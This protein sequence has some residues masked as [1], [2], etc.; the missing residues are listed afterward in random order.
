MGFGVW[1]LGFGVWGLGFGVWGLG[2]GVWGLGFG[3]GVWGFGGVRDVGVFRSCGPCFGGFY[4][5]RLSYFGGRVR[6]GYPPV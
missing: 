6:K 5:K 2:F 4:L 1:G 3:F